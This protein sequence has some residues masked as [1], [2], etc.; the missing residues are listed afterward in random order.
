MKLSLKVYGLVLIIIVAISLLSG[1]VL[2]QGMDDMGMGN[3]PTSTTDLQKYQE[4]F[5]SVWKNAYQSFAFTP[6]Q[7]KRLNKELE[8]TSKQLADNF[9]VLDSALNQKTAN[10]AGDQKRIDLAEAERDLIISQAKM[11]LDEFLSKEQVNLILTAGFH[12]VSM[13]NSGEGHLSKI[14]GGVMIPGPS[15]PMMKELG[16]LAE[17]LN[18]NCKAVTLELIRNFLAAQTKAN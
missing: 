6:E 14:H 5:K 11:T 15:V 18:L 9:M 16:S 1:S 7:T 8:T 4:S 17:K 12:G 2:A 10:K 3:K 13:S